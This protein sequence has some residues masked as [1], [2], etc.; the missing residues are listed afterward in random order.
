[1]AKPASN[2]LRNKVVAEWRGYREP[3]VT[4]DHQNALSSLL[5]KAME[6]LGLGDRVLESDVLRAWREVVG[7]FIAMH[8][9]PSRLREGVLYVRVLQPTIHFELERV[10]KADILRK[11]KTKFGAR[12]IREVRFRVG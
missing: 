1:M 8:S 3:R 5:G 7:D 9:T 10:W 2:S 4:A 11:L 12:V 6:G